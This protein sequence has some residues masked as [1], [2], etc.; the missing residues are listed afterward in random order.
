MAQ[1]YAI[2]VIRFPQ[3]SQHTVHS[4]N[5]LCLQSSNYS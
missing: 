4:I 5:D 2:L 1:L 3:I